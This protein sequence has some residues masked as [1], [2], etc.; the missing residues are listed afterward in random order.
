M[1]AQPGGRTTPWRRSHS[2]TTLGPPWWVL[3]LLGLDDEE[4]LERYGR[5]YLPGRDPDALRR[6]ALVILGNTGHA[7]RDPRNGGHPVDSE[8]EAALVRYLGGESELLAG[9]AAWAAL[10]LGRDD[11]VRPHRHRS[12]VAAELASFQPSEQQPSQQPP[13]IDQTGAS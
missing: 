1:P 3:D 11:L 13:G 7:G 9:H 12:A 8:V 4:V 10:A 2:A 6:N 5:W